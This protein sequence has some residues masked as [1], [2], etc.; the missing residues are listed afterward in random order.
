MDN[1]QTHST[2]EK[3]L[4]AELNSIEKLKSNSGWPAASTI[5]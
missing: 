4:C 5:T 2:S 3:S 1:K